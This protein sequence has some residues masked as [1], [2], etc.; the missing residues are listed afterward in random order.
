MS[1]CASSN[2]YFTCFSSLGRIVNIFLK[3]SFS[4]LVTIPSALA[5]FALKAIAAIVKPILF[6]GVVSNLL[7]ITDKVSPI[8]SAFNS[9]EI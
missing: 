3:A 7:N 4:W 1:F 2:T 5:I 6:S 8:L 9:F